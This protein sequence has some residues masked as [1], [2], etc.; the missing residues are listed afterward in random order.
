MNAEANGFAHAFSTWIA[1]GGG[2]S[3]D[4][5]MTMRYNEGPM[6]GMTRD[7]AQM[8][9]QN[10]VWKNAASECKDEYAKR[11]TMGMLAPSEAKRSAPVDMGSSGEGT[12]MPGGMPTVSPPMLEPMG[13]P[14]SAMNTPSV[15]PTAP[16]ESPTPSIS[17][18]IM[19]KSG[20]GLATDQPTFGNRKGTG[21]S[22]TGRIAQAKF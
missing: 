20:N 15:A 1:G 7:Q 16:T 17:P 4:K 10:E 2:L 12:Q 9:F 3:A 6:K 13:P 22:Q 8:K 11:A 21:A 19:Q 5:K 14:K 18:P